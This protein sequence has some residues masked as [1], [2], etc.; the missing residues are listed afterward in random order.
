MQLTSIYL[1][2][3]AFRSLQFLHRRA[4]DKLIQEQKVPKILSSITLS[5]SFTSVDNIVSS[6]LPD[7][8]IP[9]G[10]ITPFI[11][12]KTLQYAGTVAMEDGITGETLMMS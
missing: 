7:V 10:Q 9:T 1:A 8:T 11:A 6:D 3:K 12:Q 4:A 5:R 2:M